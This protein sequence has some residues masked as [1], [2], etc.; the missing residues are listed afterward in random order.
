MSLDRIIASLE[1]VL[2]VFAAAPLLASAADDIYEA[3]LFSVVIEAANKEGA[4]TSWRY[5]DG[6]L[7]SQLI[8]RR[9]PGF[10]HAG[11]P[12]T[13]ALLEFPNKAPLEVHVGVRI[14]GVS[15]LAHECDVAVLTSSE[16]DRSRQG[17][18]LPRSRG[19]IVAIE[20]KYYASSLPLHLGRGFLGLGKDLRSAPLALA[21]NITSDSVLSLVL[22]H[23]AQAD[24]G[25][26]PGTQ[27]HE[28]LIQF[29]SNK[30]HST[31][32]SRRPPLVGN[33]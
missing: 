24:D 25:V 9:S 32:E 20:A 29:V 23:K 31:S 13:H 11:G 15:G 3:F 2:S 10:I 30:F 27:A 33:R 26:L 28:R 1:R 19:L 21:T 16:G 6:R 17:G 12:F 5:S 14:A 8:F 7:A 18:V 22:H 4:I